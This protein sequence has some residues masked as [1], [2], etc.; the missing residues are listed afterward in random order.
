MRTRIFL[1]PVALCCVSAAHIYMKIVPITCRYAGS[2]DLKEI[3]VDAVRVHQNNPTAVAF[4]I[5][6]SRILEAVLLGA[7]SIPEAL[8]TVQSNIQGDLSGDG[9]TA[10]AVLEAFARAKTFAAEKEKSLSD[11]LGELSREKMKDNP[12]SPFY[13]LAARS[14]ALPGVFIGPLVLLYRSGTTVDSSYFAQALR[15][16]IL[17]SGD[18]CSR[19]VFLGAVLGAAAGSLPGDWV[20]QMDTE[21]KAKM[22]ALAQTIASLHDGAKEVK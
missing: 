12:E 16:N 18:T 1:T 19:S 17:A 10:Q 2:K 20:A 7:T 14:C 5:A 15:E 9:E 8:D 4:G 11:I 22:D 6:A 21:T 3:V 13:N